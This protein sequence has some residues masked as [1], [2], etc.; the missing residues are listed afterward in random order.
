M[1]WKCGIVGDA[2]Y[3][4]YHNRLEEKKM[5]MDSKTIRKTKEQEED[6]RGMQSY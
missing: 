1:C 3:E 2:T 6:L 5:F 4:L